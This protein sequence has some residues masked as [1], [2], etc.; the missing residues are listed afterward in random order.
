MT[1]WPSPTDRP[2]YPDDH[3]SARHVSRGTR[4][5][6]K[7]S[8]SADGLGDG[9]G[10]RTLART[11]GQDEIAR[12]GVPHCAANLSRLVAVGDCALSSI[13]S[14][15]GA[16][17]HR[18]QPA[19]GLAS[20]HR[21]DPVHGGRADGVLGF[22]IS[23]EPRNSKLDRA[24]RALAAIAHSVGV[25]ACGRGGA[26]VLCPRRTRRFG[27]R[28]RNTLTRVRD[29]EHVI[30]EPSAWLATASAQTRLA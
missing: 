21:R 2:D 1:S 14:D 23:G 19:P 9:G 7:D 15:T 25:L 11:A 5:D 16:G 24:P 20:G 29:Q 8:D 30:S 17:R 3:H 6:A 10:L 12:L 22:H 26:T 13:G 27:T 18:A 4:P 28:A